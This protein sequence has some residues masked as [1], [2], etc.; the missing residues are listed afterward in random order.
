MLLVKDN[1]LPS[2]SPILKSLK[3]KA[4][5]QHGFH[6]EHPETLSEW[7]DGKGEPKNI[8]ELL[9]QEMCAGSK[10]NCFE[11]WINILDKSKTLGWHQDKDE[12]VYTTTGVTNYAD[13]SLVYYGYPHVVKGGYIE[14]AQDTDVGD[15]GYNFKDTERIRPVYNR[16]IVFQP[17]RFHRVMPIELGIRYGFQVNVWYNTPQ[18]FIDV[19]K[20]KTNEQS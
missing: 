9:I 16:L 14:L 3:D 5:W 8:W 15:N 10:S 17:S 6:M 11:Y 2:D 19:K 18:K 20:E 1:F 7:W 12:H 13:L 4:T